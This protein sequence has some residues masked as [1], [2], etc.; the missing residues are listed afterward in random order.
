M[1]YYL[2]GEI[3]TH[4]TVQDTYIKYL[5]GTPMLLRA[6]K[7]LL[8]WET[9]VGTI[10]LGF[11]VTS[12][13]SD[14]PWHMELS[15]EWKTKS[16]TFPEKQTTRRKPSEQNPSYT[17]CRTMLVNFIHW[18]IPQ[19]ILLLR[20]AVGGCSQEKPP[21]WLNLLLCLCSFGLHSLKGRST[22]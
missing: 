4:Q 1:K 12:L 9:T 20:Q 19:Q 14:F 7:V 17:K 5:H 18:D 21:L 6:L 8:K 11:A 2:V 13:C 15:A 3:T 22:A 10:A 16:D